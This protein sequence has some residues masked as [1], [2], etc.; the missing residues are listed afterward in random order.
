MSVSRVRFALL[1]ETKATQREGGL[2]RQRES[3]RTLGLC[4][5]GKDQSQCA[6]ETTGQKERKGPG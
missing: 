5:D 4:S 2:F 3:R 6:M 1:G